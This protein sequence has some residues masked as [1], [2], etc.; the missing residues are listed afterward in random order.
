MRSWS[1]HTERRLWRVQHCSGGRGYVRLSIAGGVARTHP[2]ALVGRCPVLYAKPT[3]DVRCPGPPDGADE[4]S[5]AGVMRQSRC[6]RGV[7]VLGLAGALAGVAPDGVSA[8][9]GRGRCRATAFVANSRSGT[10]STIDVKTR[11][12]N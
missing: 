11:A 10:V 7:V 8:V 4:D 9:A 1:R 2:V 6:V 12:K 5:Q 3:C